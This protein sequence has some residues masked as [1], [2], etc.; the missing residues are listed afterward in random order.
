MDVGHG[1]LRIVTPFHAFK[2]FTKVS[3]NPSKAGKCPIAKM[4]PQHLAVSS[5]LW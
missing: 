3:T 5:P 1:L 2:S 4:S